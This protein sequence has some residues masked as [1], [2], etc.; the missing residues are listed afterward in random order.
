MAT[1]G[2]RAFEKNTAN[3][4]KDASLEEHSQSN[5][6]FYNARQKRNQLL[7]DALDLFSRGE[8]PAQDLT[9]QLMIFA[10]D[11]AESKF[12]S[13]PSFIT[14]EDLVSALYLKIT[15][16]LRNIDQSMDSYQM[17]QYVHQCFKYAIV[18]EERTRDPW[19]KRL[20]ARGNKFERDVIEAEHNLKRPLTMLERNE[21]ARGC[22]G[23][24]MLKG[25]DVDHLIFLLT[26][27][28]TETSM[29]ENDVEPTISSLQSESIDGSLDNEIRDQAL[30]IAA[31]N[32]EE[33]HIYEAI[34]EMLIE[35]KQPT[36]L[37]IRKAIEFSLRDQLER[38][39]VNEWDSW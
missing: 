9:D 13:L 34:V 11:V 17:L 33:D 28:I 36:E 6:P 31:A 25:K 19:P 38:I 15:P 16:I 27:G 8:I 12:K 26:N 24:K 21:I 3:S 10:N 39:G 35:H 5:T 1:N 2:T 4:E 37:S 18:D 23:P 30:H 32:T 20:R 14:K 7:I 22:L 29:F